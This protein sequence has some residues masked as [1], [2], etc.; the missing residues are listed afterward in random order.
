M[1][2]QKISTLSKNYKEEK[3]EMNEDIIKRLKEIKK[4]TGYNQKELAAIIGVSQATL[5][6]YETG[7]C[8]IPRRTIDALNSKLG[9][10]PTWLI[11]GEGE[12]FDKAQKFVADYNA[13]TEEQ[14]EIIDK[15]IK[16]FMK[17]NC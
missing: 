16:S 1:E 7:R 14:K 3:C 8:D 11:T 17:N 6:W 15:M 4:V 12:M 10:N 5:S 2:Y 9:I 13:L